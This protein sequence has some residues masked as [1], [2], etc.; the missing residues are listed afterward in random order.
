MFLTSLLPCFPKLNALITAR[1]DEI[2]YG[3][4]NRE[5]NEERGSLDA[6]TSSQLLTVNACEDVRNALQHIITI[7]GTIHTDARLTA[8]YYLLL[9]QFDSVSLSLQISEAI[10]VVLSVAEQSR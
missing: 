5:Q 8:F 4:C 10:G 7:A 2:L 6:A 3:R 1:S 9:L